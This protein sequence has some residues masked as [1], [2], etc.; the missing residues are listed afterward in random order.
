MDINELNSMNVVAQFNKL[1]SQ[2]GIANSAG[3]SFACM[4]E[5]NVSN[6]SF[7]S[8]NVENKASVENKNPTN[9]KQEKVEAKDDASAVD[10]SNKKENVSKTE[11]TTG[12]EKTKKTESETV[13]EKD[14]ANTKDKDVQEDDAVAPVTAPVIAEATMPDVAEEN[15]A[16]EDISYNDV[17]ISAEPTNAVQNIAPEENFSLS[18][19]NLLADVSSG[20]SQLL[21]ENDNILNL[22]EIKP[23]DISETANLTIVNLQTDEKVQIKGSDLLAQQVVEMQPTD[24][25]YLTAKDAMSMVNLPETEA[26]PEILPQDDTFVVSQNQDNQDKVATPN[27]NAEIKVETPVED[28]VKQ[29]SAL[30]SAKPQQL[31][32]NIETEEKT[33]VF[34]EEVVVDEEEN[35]L[36]QVAVNKNL[37]VDVTVK[38]EK[39]SFVNNK[40]LLKDSLSLQETVQ[41]VDA[42][43][44][45]DIS[46]PVSNK[47]TSSNQ[48]INLN[49]VAAT[50]TMATADD[51]ASVHNASVTEV[52]Q[53]SSTSATSQA[54]LSGAEL[55]ASAKA[56]AAAKSHQTTLN[57]VYKGMSKEAVEQVKVNITKSAVKGV[58]TIEVN[59]KPEDLG[60]IEIKMQIKDGKLHAHIIS[61]RQETMEALQRDAQVLEKAFND[62]GFQTD[63]NSLSF[64]FRHD[65]NQAQEQHEQLRNFIG[66]VFEEEANSDVQK[67]EAANQNWITEK[68]V[69]IRV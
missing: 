11:K 43:A 52:K 1:V 30:S 68:S 35:P 29:D 47:T 38:E 59:L 42:E 61:S 54:T 33:P 65:G 39:I 28:G 5:K 40:D 4:L 48:N 26:K 58:D 31:K 8:N 25:D 67:A 6:I 23:E 12:K 27:V 10:K 41:N 17:E 15:V 53:V 22:Q 37:K 57:D 3:E 9:D 50:Q 14:V 20:K 36:E 60:H 13:N 66:K 7:V 56:D 51:T 49:T 62:A 24:S 64:S 55:V 21:D 32:T 19:Q 46:Q 63:A 18:M 45:Q 16:V 2:T 69:N 34:N 44:A